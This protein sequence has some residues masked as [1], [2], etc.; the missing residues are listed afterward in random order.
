MAEALDIPDDKYDLHHPASEWR[1]EIVQKLLGLSGDKDKVL[2]T[3]LR[4]GTP[5]G[6]SEDIPTWGLVPNARGRRILDL[7]RPGGPRMLHRQPRQL[8]RAAR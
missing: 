3:W 5:M 7:G 1:H 6:I 8:L 2:G 4:D